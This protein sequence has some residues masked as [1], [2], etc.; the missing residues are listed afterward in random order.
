MRYP[1]PGFLPP[2]HFCAYLLDQINKL[3][4]CPRLDAIYKLELFVKPLRTCRLIY[5]ATVLYNKRSYRSSVCFNISDKANGVFSIILTIVA[6]IEKSKCNLHV[7]ILTTYSS[8]RMRCR[9]ISRDLIIAAFLQLAT[10]DENLL[11]DF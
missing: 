2:T 11:M 10:H 8:A 7:H 3:L 1:T 4:V 6:A 5:I 9:S